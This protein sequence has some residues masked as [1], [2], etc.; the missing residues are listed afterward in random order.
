MSNHNFK[1]RIERLRKSIRRECVSYNELH[2]L[3]SLAPHI[4]RGD[5]EMLEWAGVPENPENP[6]NAQAHG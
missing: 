4:D 6:D 3:Q 1:R 2:E 5:V